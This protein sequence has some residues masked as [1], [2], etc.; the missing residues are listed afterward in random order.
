E[1]A[2]GIY[3]ALGLARGM[4]DV[5]ADLGAA[6][7]ELGQFDTALGH[8][9]TGIEVAVTHELKD[10]QR[11]LR[12]MLSEA[13][14]QKGDA[15]MALAE[16][17]IYHRLERELHDRETAKRLQQIALREEIDRALDDAREQA[18]KS[19]VLSAANVALQKQTE[20]LDRIAYE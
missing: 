15:V 7:L 19:A 12:R 3:R 4:A 13:Y 18:E 2:L 11:R 17:K 16:Y 8:L 14:E 10:H 6:L 20:T 9:E 1:K 5:T